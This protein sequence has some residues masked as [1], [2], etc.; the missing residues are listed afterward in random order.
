MTRDGVDALTE[1]GW[2]FCQG[3]GDSIWLAPRRDD[4]LYIVL[5]YEPV[6]VDDGVSE[7]SSKDTILYSVIAA[8][9]W[10]NRMSLTQSK[11]QPRSEAPIN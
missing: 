6:E 11:R 3:A 7:Q 4:S 10:E 5:G 8:D 9:S 1:A 2:I